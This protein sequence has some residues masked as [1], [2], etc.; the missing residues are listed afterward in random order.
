MSAI[1]IHVHEHVDTGEILQR[2]AGLDTKV[3]ALQDRID[4]LMNTIAEIRQDL[5]DTKGVVQQ[6]VTFI[7]NNDAEKAALKQQIADLIAKAAI[8]QA[9][10][11]AL[12]ADID[13]AFSEAEDL[14]NTAR[15]GLPGVPPVGG[16]PL[17]QSYADRASFDAAVLAYTGPEEVD[18]VDAA[19]A[20]TA[21][22]T[23]TTPALTYFT[24][25]ATGAVDTTG[26]TD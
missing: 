19:G 5:A 18:V 21:V 13:A 14:E 15:A 24:H 6:L 20:A 22:K 11:D 2:L 23:G 12:Q 7:Q 17:D 9:A 3:T 25:S 26:P 1:E 10:K 8:D 16:T 4:T